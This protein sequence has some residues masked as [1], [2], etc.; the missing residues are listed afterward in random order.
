MASKPNLGQTGEFALLSRRQVAVSITCV[1]LAMFLTALGQTTVATALPSIVADLGGFD[2]YVWV[3]TA[4]MVAATVAAPVA[5]GLSDLYG[6]KPFFI[7]GLTVFIAASALLGVSHSMDALIAFRALQGIGG[8]LIMTA[9]LVS[10]ADL[11]PPEERGKYLGSLTGVYGVASVV[12]P[13]A[14]GFIAHHY[15]WHWIF[16]LNVPI[17]IPILLALIRF[18]PRGN[19]GTERPTPDYAGMIALAL[20]VVPLFLALSLGGV[21]YAWSSPQCLGLLGFGL[22]MAAAFVFVESRAEFPIMSLE[23]YTNL[24]LASAMLVVLL[25]GFVLYG[26]VIFLPL[27]FQGVLGAS[28][29][30]A[31]KLLVPILPALII[32]A[33][34][35]GQLLSRTGGHYRLQ[36]LITTMLTAVG[37]YLISTMNETTGV[38]LMETYI[39]ITGLGMGGTLAVLAAAIQNWTPFRLVGA[40]TSA[41]QFWRNVGGMMGLSAT[42]AILVQSFRSGVD[43]VV[44]DDVRAALPDGFLD[45]IKDNPQALLDPATAASLGEGLAGTESGDIPVAESLLE[46]LNVALADGLSNVFTV[47]AVAAALSFAI[48]WFLR[49]RTDA[50]T[51]ATGT[52]A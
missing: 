43:A 37:T 29:T 41:N 39:V 27:F 32:G 13:V 23:L 21:Q 4:Y 42:G 9:S 28:A 38:V 12:G 18:F 25:T 45:S 17:A 24:T 40:G 47:L 6:R 10:V 20:A 19:A 48:A 34:V 51:E 31:S 2:R 3:A 14:G 15:H 22:A 46:S 52:E 33:I 11:F 8:G 49:A 7:I 5:G 50:E 16:W 35:S 1:T 30:V 36:A 44:T 26:T